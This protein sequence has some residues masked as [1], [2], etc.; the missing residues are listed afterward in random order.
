M[1][2][3]HLHTGEHDMHQTFRQTRTRA[4]GG[5]T[6]GIA[7]AVGAVGAAWAFDA[8]RR[9][10]KASRLHRTLVDLLLNALHAGDARTERHSRRVADLTDALAETYGLDSSRRARLRIASLLHDLGKIDDDL[11]EVVHS[12]DRLSKDDRRRIEEHPKG[13]ANILRPLEKI[14]PGITRIVE[15]HHESWDGEGYPRGQK[16]GQIPLEARILGVADV[17]DAL[18]QP[19][20]YHSAIS[21][22]QALQKIRKSAGEKFD[23]E[24]ADRVDRPEVLERWKEIAERGHQ[25]ERA[26]SVKP[27]RAA[28]AT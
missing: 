4:P 16:G 2:S 24:V 19:R 10:R 8:W 1:R 15:A 26:A 9:E 21:V 7:G 27:A 11:F 20:P 14:H 22:D 23:P 17:F 6:I 12:C 25:E 28:A 13:G 3:G 18:T 5:R